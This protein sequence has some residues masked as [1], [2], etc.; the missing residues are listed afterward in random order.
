MF[1]WQT[2]THMVLLRW[3]LRWEALRTLRPGGSSRDWGAELELVV[4]MLAR[5]PWQP[6]T[7]T[8]HPD[9]P[10][11]ANL[12]C[13]QPQASFELCANQNHLENV[14]VIAV[15]AAGCRL[16]KLKPWQLGIAA[17]KLALSRLVQPQSGSDLGNHPF[18]WDFAQ[19]R[20]VSES[21]LPECFGCHPHQVKCIR[22]FKVKIHYVL[23]FWEGR[24]CSSTNEL[25]Y[26]YLFHTLVRHG[27]RYPAWFVSSPILL[28][29]TC[30]YNLAI[31]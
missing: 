20:G 21:A 6:P 28:P 24:G 4:A 1:H 5:P 8:S 29:V 15:S 13:L 23:I 27:S 31:P 2:H 3:L 25:E 19:N 17:I 16:I 9:H 11:I 10:T 12:N 14:Q 30:P 26:I 7:Q 22:Y 18:I